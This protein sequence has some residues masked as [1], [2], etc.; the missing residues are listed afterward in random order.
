SFF[1]YFYPAF[2]RHSV[3]AI[4]SLAI[5]VL[6]CSCGNELFAQS[7]SEI[8]SEGASSFHLPQFTSSIDSARHPAY[9]LAEYGEPKRAYDILLKSESGARRQFLFEARL[10]TEI[11][12]Y[13]RAD[14][15]LT[16]ARGNE[17]DNTKPLLD[18]WKARLHVLAGRHEEAL[19]YVE[20]SGLDLPA[21]FE[22]Y[23]QILHLEALLGCGKKEAAIA[24]GEGLLHS[25]GNE[26]VPLE[27]WMSL[28][29]I[30]IGEDS[31][32]K[33][34]KLTADLSRRSMIPQEASRLAR[35]E[36]DLLY[37]LG[38]VSRARQKTSDL[39]KNYPKETSTMV[40]AH[41]T[42]ANMALDE[43]SSEELI[44]FSELLINNSE[45]SEGKKL[46]T[47][48]DK[49][50]LNALDAEKSKML[51]ANL[52]YKQKKFA[53]AAE[54][55]RQKYSTPSLKRW[56]TLLLARCY[57]SMGRQLSSARL[58]EDFSAKFPTDS[59]AAEALFVASEMYSRVGQTGKAT[60]ALERL[61]VTYASGYFGHIATLKL[62]WQHQENGRHEESVK[63][64][65]MSLKQSN[66]YKETMLYY[67]AG[68]YE[69]LNMPEKQEL[70]L[71]NLAELDS[72]SFYLNQS[73]DISLPQKLMSS[74]GVAELE[75]EDG[76][77]EFLKKISG[78]KAQA[79]SQIVS[80]LPETEDKMRYASAIHHMEA[81]RIFFD[82][83]F[84][85]WG[86]KELSVA[87]A[88]LRSCKRLIF[89]LAMLYDHYGMTWNS[90][91]WYQ[92]VWDSIHGEDRRRLSGSFSLLLYPL[93]FPVQVFENCA[94]Q[95][96]P[97]HLVYAMIRAESGFN[98]TAV[99]RA[100]AIGLMQ[101]MPGTGKDVAR[102]LDL[103]DDF[104]EDLFSPEINL[105]F[106]IWYASF[107]F[108]KCGEDPLMMFAAYNAGLAN[109]KRW[110]C[111]NER[112]HSIPRIVDGITYKETRNYVKKIV[113]ST[114]IYRQLYFAPGGPGGFSEHNQ[115]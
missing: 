16:W 80:F 70:A 75:G 20:L 18:L 35:R 12:L 47:S 23:R 83:G 55:S 36:I 19:S 3:S 21:A 95:G 43:L 32:L 29:D 85:D 10:L 94:R 51:M 104:N 114:H 101:L 66:R 82:M 38:D 5:L 39:V 25:L 88:D 63:L 102:Q 49:R 9:L 62:A 41:W 28:L 74:R 2:L 53:Q 110:F 1:E 58:Y 61:A 92:F 87:E 68:A 27:I 4:F 72:N 89:Q 13:D 33:A 50:Q 81:G 24:L 6:T 109:A 112:E 59:K 46:L 67:L 97:P 65:E 86:T 103:P 64:L 79:T 11:G 60:Q 37:Q 22:P 30:Y 34:A 40:A 44:L 98:R 111:G 42:L 26:A 99:S 115:R 14:S 76:L 71:Q 105:A 77:I 91:K 100:G 84:H 8:N 52:F 93:P 69:R 48:L 57:R 90:M 7:A 45:L 106:G 56:S 108:S 96:L 31:L 15:A 78:K 113:E 107:L 54:L 17:P 73:I